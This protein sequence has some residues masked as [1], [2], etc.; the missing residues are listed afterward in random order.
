MDRAEAWKRYDRYFTMY[1]MALME[2]RMARIF[3][4]EPD[5]CYQYLRM[6]AHERRQ[7][8]RVVRYMKACGY[9]D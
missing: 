2:A 6:A 1:R 5:R 8:F 9:L 4:Y 7:L 3:W